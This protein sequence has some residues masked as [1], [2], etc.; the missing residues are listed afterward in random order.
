MPGAA[1][2]TDPKLASRTSVPTSSRDLQNGWL[3]I[4][5]C[6]C[7]RIAE[8]ARDLS[9]IP[10]PCTVALKDT[11]ASRKGSAATEK[12]RMET[13]I[14]DFDGA[15]DSRLQNGGAARHDPFQRV[16]AGVRIHRR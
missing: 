3:A 15:V 9:S 5:E 14:K 12:A 1:G 7:L 4:Q 11:L 8:A 13:P 6:T 16:F 2:P 10:S